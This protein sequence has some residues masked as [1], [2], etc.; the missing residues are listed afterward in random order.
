MSPKVK[1]NLAGLGI[2]DGF[3][4]PVDSSIYADFLYQ[5]SLVGEVERD[6]LL[7]IEQDMKYSCNVGDY[8]KAW[9]VILHFLADSSSLN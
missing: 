7:E 1:I 8:Y 2:G 6:D 4:S 5:A 9:Q 3:M